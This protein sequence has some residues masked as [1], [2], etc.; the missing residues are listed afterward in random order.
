MLRETVSKIF[1]EDRVETLFDTF[2][3]EFHFSKGVF[4]KSCW[5][6]N[7]EWRF[8]LALYHNPISSND[9]SSMNEIL[10]SLTF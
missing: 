7:D 5:D 10:D 3:Y 1:N 9:I 4:V 6:F 8:I 2:K